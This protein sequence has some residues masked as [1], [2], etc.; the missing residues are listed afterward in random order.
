MRKRRRTACLLFCMAICLC[1]CG[2]KETG[3]I[4]V[5]E[6][7]ES[8]EPEENQVE[9]E[10]VAVLDVEAKPGAILGE[11]EITLMQGDSLEEVMYTRVQA[12]QEASI[13]YDPEHFSMDIEGEGICLLDLRSLKSQI[14]IREEQGDSTESLVDTYVYESNEECLVEDVTIG[15]GEYPATWVSYSEGTE[16]DDRTCDLYVLRYNERLYVIRLDCTVSLYE[17]VGEEQQMILSTLRFD[18]G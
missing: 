10:I 9:E 2:K 16:E 17:E 5:L 4:V 7:S 1:G 11:E 18:E 3:E 14:S 8:K 15:E 6:E 13:A 12:A